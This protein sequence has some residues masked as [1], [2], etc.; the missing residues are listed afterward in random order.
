MLIITILL[1]PLCLARSFAVL[2]HFMVVGILSILYVIALFIFEMPVF[3]SI[4]RP[5]DNVI[6]A[7]LSWKIFPAISVATF[8][9]Y[10]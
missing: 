5:L 1:Y 10:T 6:L 9:Y 8:A 7:N 3:Y 4:Y 2:L